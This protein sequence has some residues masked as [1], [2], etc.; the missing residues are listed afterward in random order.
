MDRHIFREYD[1]RGIV[2]EDLTDSD[3]ALL[4]KAMGT[5]LRRRGRKRI[6]LGRDCRLS[7]EGFRDLMAEGLTKCGLDV[8]D[9][10]VCPTPLLYFSI[11]HFETDGGVMI[12]ASHNPP[13]YNG[14]K[15]CDGPDTIFGADIMGL[16]DLAKAGDFE[17]GSGG[18]ATEDV[19]GP[20]T[21]YVKQNITLTRPLKIA[22]DGGNAVAGPVGLPLLRD[23]GVE[24]TP[25]YCEMDGTFPNHEP[26]PTVPDNVRDMIRTVT[27]Q[28][29]DCG[30]GYDGDGD[31]IGVV[32][33]NGR[34]IFGDMLLLIFA[35]EILKKNPGATFVGEVKCSQFLYDDIK[36]RGGNPIMWRTG[37]SLIKNKM[38]EVKAALAGEM[39]GHMFFADRYFGYDDA[40]YASARLLEILSATDQPLSS[41][42]ADVPE[43][44][45]TPEIRVEC[46]DD[47][48][49]AVVEKIASIARA[50]GLEFID[51][52]GVRLTFPDGWGLVRAS[53]TQPVLVM[54]FEAPTEERAHEIRDLVEELIAEAK[55][56]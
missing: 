13:H 31:R 24:V 16:Y 22:L 8:L 52:D 47:I 55:A 2:D 54:R 4:A 15:V 7:S 41:L 34:I 3:V 45:T 29:L 35:R 14:F 42:L 30:I 44:Y 18:L 56:S 49:F 39:S 17:T 43:R 40:I 46:P 33:E 32:D 53:N 51:V 19:I 21:E 6:T 25:L 26:D 50:R 20:Y 23:L 38:K 48:K 27:D 10:G 1:V 9:L 37:H 5:F 11:R 28:K 12:T 36:A